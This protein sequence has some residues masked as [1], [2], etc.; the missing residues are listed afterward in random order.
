LDDLLA[1]LQ[2]DHIVVLG[3]GYPIDGS[4]PDPLYRTGDV[5]VAA[6]V[7]LLGVPDATVLRPSPRLLHGISAAAGCGSA[8]YRGAVAATATGIS[9]ASQFNSLHADHVS[10]PV[11]GG[12]EHHAVYLVVA[13]HRSEWASVKVVGDPKVNETERA[14]TTLAAFILNTMAEGVFDPVR[15][16]DQ[17][18]T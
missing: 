6:E 5:V 9:D 14:A 13:R 17:A 7:H 12:A 11:V 18:T 8:V 3:I 1:G 16:P 4:G 2:P 10:G 15:R